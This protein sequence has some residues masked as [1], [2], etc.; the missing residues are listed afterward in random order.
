V[1]EECMACMVG[2]ATG[3]ESHSKDCYASHIPMPEQ[4]GQ[5]GPEWDEYDRQVARAREEL[6]R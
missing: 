4:D 6:N 1:M 5:W 3:P 2:V